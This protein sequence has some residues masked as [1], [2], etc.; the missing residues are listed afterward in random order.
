MRRGLRTVVP[1][2]EGVPVPHRLSGTEASVV[3]ITL[4]LASALTANGMPVTA[5]LQLL[6]GAGLTGGL[7]LHVPVSVSPLQ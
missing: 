2:V 4:V 7:V 6:A 1:C 3:V 5:V